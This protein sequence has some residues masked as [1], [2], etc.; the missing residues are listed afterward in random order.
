MGD[1]KYCI[2]HLFIRCT[3]HS[4]KILDYVPRALLTM[5]H[6]HCWQCTTGI[7]DIRQRNGTML[8]VG[9]VSADNATVSADNA[10]VLADNATVSADNTT[11]SADNVSVGKHYDNISWHC[12]NISWHRDIIN[13]LWQCQLKLSVSAD[14]TVSWYCHCQLI[15]SQCRLIMSQC[16]LIMIVSADIVSVSW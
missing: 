12:D 16:Q 13:W 3:K 2:P 9:S 4:H 14:N 7:A 6:G 10:T 11:V 8:A 1:N 5:Y 15:M